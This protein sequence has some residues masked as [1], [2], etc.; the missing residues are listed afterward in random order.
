MDSF[1]DEDAFL[2]EL[3]FSINPYIRGELSHLEYISGVHSPANVIHTDN[4]KH[5]PLTE[6]ILADNEQQQPQTANVFYPDNEQQRPLTEN[7]IADNEQ[8]QPQTENVFH[9]DNEQ[10]QPATETV[11]RADAKQPQEQLRRKRFADPVTDLSEWTTPYV[12]PNTRKNTNW[13]ISN[14]ESWRN[15]YNLHK[16]TETCPPDILE[17][18]SDPKELS[19]W[20]S[21]F[22]I[23]TRTTEGK[24][25]V[26]RTIIMLLAGLHRFVVERN[27]YSEYL[28][29]MNKKD[30]S[31]RGLWSTCDRL[32][33]QLR[34][35]GIGSKPK[36]TTLISSEDEDILW[37]KGI[38]GSE[39]PKAL[40]NA[41][42]YLNGKNFHLR[43]GDE[44]KFL[45]ISQ[46]QY[47]RNP[48]RFEYV[49]GGSKNHPGGVNEVAS[50][51]Q[52]KIVPLM[53]NKQAGDR[54]HVQILQ[55]YLSKIPPTAYQHDYFYLRPVKEF[56]HD[57]FW[58]TTQV[59]GKN[60]LSKMVSNMFLQAGIDKKVTNHSLRATG[61]TELYRC[62]V[63]EKIIMQRTGHKSMDGVRVYE[64]TSAEQHMAVSKIL[65]EQ[66]SKSGGFHDVVKTLE[67][68]YHEE[69]HHR[70]H[71]EAENLMPLSSG[72]VKP[73]ALFS[74][75]REA[76]YIFQGCNVTFFQK[77]ENSDLDSFDE[78]I[79]KNMDKLLD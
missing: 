32:F 42:F 23:G 61:T 33:R 63:P 16:T 66:N 45:R 41:V 73:R 46:F 3:Q 60:T 38:L 51:V 43:G 9:P 24:E 22:V 54:C 28:N 4:E 49:E 36:T 34:G 56:S 35:K 62:G 31:F 68:P 2:N 71:S 78:L 55:K 25:Y 20:L 26:P 72:R 29:F 58:Y 15:A 39:T 77:D 6:D 76:K 52:N 27:P 64:R 5:Q 65:T 13:A 18:V 8:Q 19:K 67:K 11:L 57:G 69:M 47:H 53:A 7:V 17:N 40:L 21:A 59:I 14:F 1:F 70:A 48:E 44:H 79:L 74:Q 12:P 30:P 75:Q 37:E 10:Q 50:S